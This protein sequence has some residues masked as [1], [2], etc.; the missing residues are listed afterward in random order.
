MALG[1]GLSALMSLFFGLSSGV[2]AFGIFW[3]L[4][5]WFQGMGFPPCAN[6]LTNWFAPNERGMKFS[7]WNTSHSIGAG[8]VLILNSYL[9][10]TTGAT[11][12]L[13]RLPWDLLVSGSF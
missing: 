1:L 8:L 3:L 12:S 5:G 2:I 7:I 6:S 10:A 4:N 11:V 9:V 13:F